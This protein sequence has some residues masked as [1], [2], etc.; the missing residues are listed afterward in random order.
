MYVMNI[1]HNFFFLAFDF[2]FFF[3]FLHRFQPKSEVAKT[4]IA[5]FYCMHFIPPIEWNVPPVK[6]F[7]FFFFLL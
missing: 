1:C 4:E 7:F 2:F 6:V 3:F 5:R